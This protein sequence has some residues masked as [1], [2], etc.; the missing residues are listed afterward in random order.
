MADSA[1]IDHSLAWMGL[2][3]PSQMTELDM[4][5]HPPSTSFL[6]VISP[7]QRFIAYPYAYGKQGD[8]IPTRWDVWPRSISNIRPIAIPLV[9][10]VQGSQG[11]SESLET[12]PNASTIRYSSE[13]LSDAGALVD[14]GRILS[15]E[16][17][18]SQLVDHAIS[19][20]HPLDEVLSAFDYAICQASTTPSAGQASLRPSGNIKAASRLAAFKRLHRKRELEKREHERMV[21][22]QEGQIYA[23]GQNSERMVRVWNEMVGE[24]FIESAGANPPTRISIHLIWQIVSELEE[25]GVTAEWKRPFNQTGARNRRRL[26]SYLAGAIE[27]CYG[28]QLERW[29]GQSGAYNAGRPIEP[30]LIHSVI[31]YVSR[32]WMEMREEGRVTFESNLYVR[33][34]TRLTA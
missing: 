18:D 1:Q 6:P 26:A 33:V 30:A 22:A 17:Q 4:Q 15:F 11:H 12:A 25:G 28:P 2:P 24:Q 14:K 31:D 20:D 27:H 23:Q 3:D 16:I 21:M 5:H 10:D 32:R 34:R 9:D 8:K 13:L 7:G 29:P 19:G